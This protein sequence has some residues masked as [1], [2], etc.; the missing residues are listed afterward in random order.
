M[1]D[2]ENSVIDPVDFD[3]SYLSPK[4]KSLLNEKLQSPKTPKSIAPTN[5]TKD[6]R[7]PLGLILSPNANSLRT[8]SNHV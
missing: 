6:N 3:L 5:Q 1:D 4:G 8:R 2:K 7:S